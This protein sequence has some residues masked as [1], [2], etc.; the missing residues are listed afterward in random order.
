MQDY[1]TPLRGS[2]ISVVVTVVASAA[3]ALPWRSNPL[4]VAGIALGAAL[5]SW[6][7]FAWLWRALQSRLV[8]LVDA[9]V[10]QSV[11]RIGLST[12]VSAALGVVCRTVLADFHRYVQGGAVLAL[13]GGAYL[14]L[15]WGM[16]SAEAARLL[17]L[18][19]RRR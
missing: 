4:A 18:T 11:V 2:L 14:L 3:F 5:G 15:M 16:G 13:F 1:R 9:A 8:P 10:R 6:V 17:R 12:V 7:N 19:P